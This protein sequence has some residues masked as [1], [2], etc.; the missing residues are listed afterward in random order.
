MLD[1]DR[2]DVWNLK[3]CMLGFSVPSTLT[4]VLLQA[5]RWLLHALWPLEPGRGEGVGGMGGL[6]SSV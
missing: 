1:L 2:Q 5:K 3:V 6:N 4:H